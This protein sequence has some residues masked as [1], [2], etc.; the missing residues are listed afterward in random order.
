MKYRSQ[1]N[2][3]IQKEHRQIYESLEHIIDSSLDIWLNLNLGNKL[4]FLEVNRLWV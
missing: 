3:D 2:G 4:I 1:I